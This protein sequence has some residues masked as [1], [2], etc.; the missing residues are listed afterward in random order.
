MHPAVSKN[1]NKAW[2]VLVLVLSFD[3]QIVGINGLLQPV[4]RHWP[5][6]LALFVSLKNFQWSIKK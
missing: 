2:G 1:G 6:V 3:V 5:E 4:G